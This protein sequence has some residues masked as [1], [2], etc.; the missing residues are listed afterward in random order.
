MIFDSGDTGGDDLPEIANSIRFD[1]TN[2]YLNRTP[3]SSGNRKTFTFSGWVKRGSIG[4]TVCLFSAGDGTSSNHTSVR[5]SNGG[6]DALDFA[7]VEGNVLQNRKVTSALYRDTSAHMHIVVI[8]DTTN[9]TASDRMQ[10]WINGTRVTAF[11]TSV[12]PTLNFNSQVNITQSHR[13]ATS[14]YTTEYLDGYLSNVCFVDGQALAPSSFAY[15]D[16]NGQWRSLSKASLTALASA[17]GTNSFFLPFDNGASTTTLGYDASSK[18][19]N[20]T[21]NNMV[22]AAGATECWMTDTPTN[23]FCTLNPINYYSAGVT[24]GNGAL[25][26]TGDNTGGTAAASFAFDIATT[27]AEWQITIGSNPY[28]AIGVTPSESYAPSSSP[29][30]GSNRAYY[31]NTGQKYIGASNSVYGATFTTGDVIKVRVDNGS[32][33]FFKNGASQGVAWTGLTGIWY[34]FFGH[35]ASVTFHVDFG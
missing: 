23:N 20:W 5:I 3:A 31:G 32:V 13:I 35:A 28:A 8:L 22:R 30:S 11:S 27:Q 18:G 29:L 17:G 21:L 34:P 4:G 25:S 12:D 9:V 6:V 19:N 15:T 10:L 1:G 24:L 33:E 16:P 7:S 26:Y 14:S 2:D